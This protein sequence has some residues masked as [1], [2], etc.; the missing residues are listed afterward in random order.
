MNIR[1]KIFLGLSGML[2]LIM[3]LCVMS[4]EYLINIRQADSVAGRHTEITG[5]SYEIEIDLLEAR[6]A[7]KN[8]FLRGG[9]KNISGFKDR[10]AKIL[11]KSAGIKKLDSESD[12]AGYLSEVE[13][14]A[15]E[16]EAAFLAAAK[17]SRG[18]KA[19]NAEIAAYV[20]LA[21]KLQ[22]R[23][24][25]IV[26]KAKKEQE[27][28]I[29]W[30][31]ESTSQAISTIIFLG[32]AIIITGMVMTYYI[33]KQVTQSTGKL[34]EAMEKIA[35]GGKNVRAEVN[36]GDEME[37]MGNYF[38]R[39]LDTLDETR[40][41]AANAEKL[42]SLGTL[43]AG[44]A[45]EINNPLTG[46]LTSAHIALKELPKKHKSRED[47]EIII[48]ETMRCRDIVKGLLDFSR[49]VKAKKKK[50]SI[51]QA[52][53]K[54]LALVKNQMQ[55]CGIKAKVKLGYKIPDVI[56]D[57][58]RLEQVFLNV[59]INA[60]EAMPQGGALKVQSRLNVD[61]SELIVSDTGIGI[62]K[63]NID[64][65][66]D[67]FFTTKEAG[68]GTGLGLAVS[69]GIIR[70]YGGTIEIKSA[71]KAGTTVMIRLPAARKGGKNEK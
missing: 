24:Y 59:F 37:I 1:T 23:I 20:D 11:E 14:T 67:P 43:S 61:N 70:E 10:I 50:T 39:M 35:A 40:K 51:N 65:V 9:S 54:A 34:L 66:F 53:R 12:Y 31:R 55:S 25:P 41:K 52:A 21:R 2:A 38:N 36:S 47:L 33:P 68:K 32:L 19:V 69:Y 46:I 13:K 58:N 15:A 4:I 8:Y 3:S 71:E 56:A 29:L 48:R 62:S 44:I 17:N 49:S 18:D 30:S 27:K 42:A 57:S 5:L 64:R 7:E 26:E 6:R 28:A 63:A 45:H 16:Y 22:Q 60:I